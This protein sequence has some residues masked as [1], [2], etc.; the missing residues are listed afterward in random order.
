[1]GEGSRFEEARKHVKVS[2]YAFVYDFLLKVEV[3]IR[4]EHVLRFLCDG[5]ADKREH[6][7]LKRILEI[8]VAPHFRSEERVAQAFD[9][10]PAK[11]IGA[12]GAF[13]F[14][15]AGAGENETF[16]SVLFDKVMDCVKQR[17]DTLDLVDYNSALIGICRH[18]IDKAFRSRRQGT[19]YI[20]FKEIDGKG[21][22][23]LMAKPYRFAG[24]A[25]SEKEETTA[26]EAYH[27]LF[28]GVYDTIPPAE[29][30]PHIYIAT[31]KNASNIPVPS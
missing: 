22:L 10:T 18:D 9:G 24:A 26:W 19:A 8:E 6:P 23:E 7:E 30:Q 21:I 2:D 20:G 29:I 17:R 31:G 15:C 11:E 5:I 3:E 12:L 25:R 14:P 4:P 27:S 13:E 16:V 28:H 1:M